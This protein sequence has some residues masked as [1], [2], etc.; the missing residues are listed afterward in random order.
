MAEFPHSSL[1]SAY[2]RARAAAWLSVLDKAAEQLPV[3]RDLRFVSLTRENRLALAAHIYAAAAQPP[4]PRAGLPHVVVVLQPRLTLPEDTAFAL[5]S[6]DLLR[7]WHMV[8]GETRAALKKPPNGDT[9]PDKS[10]GDPLMPAPGPQPEADFSDVQIDVQADVLRGLWQVREAIA[11]T[12]TGMLVNADA[13][14][15]LKKAASLAPRSPAARLALAEAQLQ[16]GLPEQCVQSCGEALRLKP[17]LYRARYVR[18]LALM[19]LRQFALAEGDLNVLMAV[20]IPA[21]GTEMAGRLRTRGAVRL[22]RGDY[23]GMCEDFTA[24]CG[25]GDC[26]GLAGAR[27]QGRCLSPKGAQ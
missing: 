13:L 26:E 27:S 3:R 24:A 22:L 15:L 25:L 14:P 1:A 2:A 19:R 4:E 6:P 12:R 21:E 7:L 18:A 23:R 10:S 9:L 20:G 8:I 5:R 16:Q 17:D 11:P